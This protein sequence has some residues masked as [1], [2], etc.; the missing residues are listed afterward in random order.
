MSGAGAFAAAATF[1]TG[2][3][4]QHLVTVSQQLVPVA[5][6]EE[7]SYFFFVAIFILNFIEVVETIDDPLHQTIH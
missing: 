4:G 7:S 2:S 6:N 5:N 1:P 3:Q